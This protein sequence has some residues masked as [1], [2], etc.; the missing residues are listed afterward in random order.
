MTAV[1]RTWR[2]GAS[3]DATTN[4]LHRG[5]TWDEA[6]SWGRPYDEDRLWMDANM[7]WWAMRYLAYWKRMRRGAA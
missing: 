7:V 6:L 4:M 3:G 5:P 1:S 2:G